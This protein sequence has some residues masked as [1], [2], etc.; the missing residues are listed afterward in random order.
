M[1][2]VRARAVAVGVVLLA[3]GCS[4]DDTTGSPDEPAPADAG[5]GGTDASTVTVAEDLTGVG[6]EGLDGVVLARALV[7]PDDLTGFE[8][9]SLARPLRTG[10]RPGLLLCGQDLRAEAGLVDGVQSV[11]SRGPL[12]ITVTVSAAADGAAAARFVDRFGEVARACTTPWSQDQVPGVEGGLEAQV[13]GPADVGDPGPPVESFRIRTDG[14][15]GSSEV[16]VAVF[17]VGPVVTAVTVAGPAD[18][19]LAVASDAVAAAATRS[20]EL[21]A[22]LG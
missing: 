4:Q 18:D 9:R 8:A 14:A 1:I 6:G 10:E 20:T 21:V 16:V 3:S 22:G 11:L 15:A 13:I 7:R 17:A 5:D 12:Q 19:P 2:G